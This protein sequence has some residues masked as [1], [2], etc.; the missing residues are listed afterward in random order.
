MQCPEIELLL[1]IVFSSSQ[2]SFGTA[3]GRQGPV[4][5][6]LHISPWIRASPGAA[7][8]DGANLRNLGTKLP[9]LCRQPSWDLGYMWLPADVGALGGGTESRHFWGSWGHCQDGFGSRQPL[10]PVRC[11]RVSPCCPSPAWVSRPGA[12]CLR[13]LGLQRQ[14][15]VPQPSARNP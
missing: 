5:H 9:P 6:G 7:C 12:V 10:S 2:R 14:V 4:A 15:P 11:S 13:M 1:E 8:A 3:Q